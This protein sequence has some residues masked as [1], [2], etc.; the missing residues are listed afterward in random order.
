MIGFTVDEKALELHGFQWLNAILDSNL[1]SFIEISPEKRAAQASIYKELALSMRRA[2]LGYQLHLPY[3]VH[4]T[5]YR[6][7]S[8]MDS[9][10]K[11]VNDLENWL[12]LTETFRY[13]NNRIPIILHPCYQESTKKLD[14]NLTAH[15]VELFLRTLTKNN[16][17]NAYYLAI[18]NV[19]KRKAPG[20]GNC[21]SSLEGFR[22]STFHADELSLC[23]DLCHYITNEDSAPIDYE[24]VNLFHIHQFDSLTNQDHLSLTLGDLDFD[25]YL[26]LLSQQKNSRINLETLLYCNPNYIH[27]LALDLTKLSQSLKY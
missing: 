16:M 21:L 6:L 18:E 12:L 17:Q 24:S 13:N 3:F 15:F 8:L 26:D 22:N 14:E 9:K 2:G 19:P 5:D 7:N 1:V 11:I 27:S 23:L 20:F 25:G 10:Q 4:S